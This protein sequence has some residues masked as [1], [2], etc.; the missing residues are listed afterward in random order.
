MDVPVIPETLE[1]PLYIFNFRLKEN[2]SVK[3][4]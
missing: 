3:Q 1:P 4:P 2:Q